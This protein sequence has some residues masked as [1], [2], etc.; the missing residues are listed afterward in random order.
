MVLATLMILSAASISYASTPKVVLNGIELNFDV[1]PIVENSRTLV[2]FKSVL[3]ALGANIGWDPELQLV[4]ATKGSTEIRLWIGSTDISIN[5]NM[6]VI[7]VP[8][9]IYNGRTLVPLRVISEV[10]GARVDWDQYSQTVTINSNSIKKNIITPEKAYQ[11][12]KEYVN[13]T[14]KPSYS[15]EV[16]DSD[17][18]N[19]VPVYAVNVCYVWTEDYQSSDLIIIDKNTGEVLGKNLDHIKNCK[20]VYT[21]NLPVVNHSN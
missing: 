21:M 20:C 3:E 19:E 17:Y 1:P 11:I 5:G 4:T 14:V 7:D 15:Y 16:F 2:P 8:P 13:D 9:I 12:S 10:L 18:N 6:S